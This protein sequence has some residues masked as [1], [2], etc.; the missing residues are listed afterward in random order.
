MGLRDVM[1]VVCRCGDRFNLAKA[2]WCNCEGIKTKLCSNGHCIC[3]KLKDTTVWRPATKS[4]QN[5]GFGWMLKEE[6]GGVETPK[7]VKPD[8]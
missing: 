5:M 8:G 7:R 4:E 2:P 3:H 6:H 1:F